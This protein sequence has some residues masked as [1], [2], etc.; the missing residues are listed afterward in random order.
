MVYKYYKGIIV[1]FF[2]F[3]AAQIFIFFPS[4]LRTQIPL[5]A[6]ADGLYLLLRSSYVLLKLLSKLLH[7][8]V[9]FGHSWL[10][11]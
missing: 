3:L 8:K 9:I 5:A 10:Y 2:F 6:K 7:S 1:F 4:W 11:A